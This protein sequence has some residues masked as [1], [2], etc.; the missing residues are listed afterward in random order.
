MSMQACLLY[1]DLQLELPSIFKLN[2]ALFYLIKGALFFPL[3]Y[4][5]KMIAHPKIRSLIY[6]GSASIRRHIYTILRIQRKAAIG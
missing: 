1:K 2:T 3:I 6:K 5:L 4:H